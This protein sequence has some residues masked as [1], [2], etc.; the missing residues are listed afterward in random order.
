MGVVVGGF[1]GGAFIFNQIQ[2]KTF[3]IDNQRNE[4]C[5][6]SNQH[7]EISNPISSCPLIAYGATSFLDVLFM[8]YL[9]DCILEPEQYL[10]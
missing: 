10:H 8:L 2:V 4:M 5:K 6:I 1:G 9:T 3:F 7:P